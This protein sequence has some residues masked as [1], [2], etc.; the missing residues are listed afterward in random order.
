MGA[1]WPDEDAEEQRPETLLYAL[2]GELAAQRGL[3]AFCQPRRSST[4]VAR[5]LCVRATPGPAVHAVRYGPAACARL[6]DLAACRR[7]L[8]GSAAAAARVLQALQ[9]CTPTGTSTW[10]AAQV[11]PRCACSV[12]KSRACRLGGSAHA[13][14]TGAVFLGAAGACRTA[15]SLDCAARIAD[16]PALAVLARVHRCACFAAVWYHVVSGRKVFLAAPPTPENLQAFEEWSSSGKQA[17]MHCRHSCC[18]A[19]LLCPLPHPA[20]KACRPVGPTMHAFPLMLT[21]RRPAAGWATNSPGLCGFRWGRGTLFCCRRPGR[22]PCPRQS[23]PL[24]LVRLAAGL[25]SA[26]VSAGQASPGNRRHGAHLEYMAADIRLH[27]PGTRRVLPEQAEASRRVCRECRSPGVP[28]PP[29]RRVP[30]PCA[31]GNFLHALDFGAIAECYRREQR[32]GVTP[33]FQVQP[34]QAPDPAPACQRS[35]LKQA[36]I[37]QHAPAL[38]SCP[39]MADLHLPSAAVAL[40]SSC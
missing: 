12:K 16:R 36:R 34:Q 8:M 3:P 35:R 38:C 20:A 40:R 9:A 30:S 11:R 1:V 21:M 15:F 5:R 33:K 4:A 14:Q 18:T 6:R 31:G 25:G 13:Q 7:G 29:P 17:S 32:L 27:A 22:T 37:C 10:A 19:C 2:L 23:R 28:A 26:P 39:A 24:L